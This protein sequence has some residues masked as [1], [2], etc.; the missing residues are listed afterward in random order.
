[1][2]PRDRRLRA[3]PPPPT[4]RPHTTN[5]ATG[6]ISWIIALCRT[7]VTR[8]RN[9]VY[10]LI[11]RRIYCDI[12]KITPRSKDASRFPYSESM[13]NVSLSGFHIA[14][15]IEMIADERLLLLFFFLFCKKKKSSCF[16]GYL[17]KTQ[18]LTDC[19]TMRTR[20]IYTS[21]TKRFVRK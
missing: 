5:A 21:V 14:S 6:I 1:M 19:I 18:F 8:N 3:F 9:N 7:A 12:N 20:P 13:R 16:H 17:K 2:P 4:A 10:K 15:A 11:A